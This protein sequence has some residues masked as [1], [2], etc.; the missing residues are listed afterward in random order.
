MGAD[1][2]IHTLLTSSNSTLLSSGTDGSRQV[3]AAVDA[4]GAGTKLTPATVT[5]NGDLVS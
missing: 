5:Q 3:T 1:S 2:H 4:T